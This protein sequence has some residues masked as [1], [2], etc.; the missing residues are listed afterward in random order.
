MTEAK[1]LWVPVT[2][3]MPTEKDADPQRCVLAWHVYQGMMVTGWHQINGNQF[4]TH[5]ATPRGPE[6]GIVNDREQ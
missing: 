5:W 6:E 3:R 2:E 1:I 4:I